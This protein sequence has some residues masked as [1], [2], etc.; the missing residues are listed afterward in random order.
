MEFNEVYLIDVY[1]GIFPLSNSKSNYYSTEHEMEQEERRLF[2]VGLT[3][4]IN[5][6]NIFCINNRES[7]FVNELYSDSGSVGVSHGSNH[8][9]KMDLID[10]VRKINEE[11]HK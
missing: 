11:I 9:Y 6:L 4:A 2:Y 3:R 10:H 8:N 5:S 1:D 7:C